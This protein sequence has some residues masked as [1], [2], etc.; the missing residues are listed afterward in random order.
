MSRTQQSDS[1]IVSFNTESDRVKGIGTLFKSQ[2]K[3]EGLEKNKF[4][5]CEEQIKL[6]ENKNIK[7]SKH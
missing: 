4:R 5:V 6:F 1:I 3:F 7:Y 2:Y